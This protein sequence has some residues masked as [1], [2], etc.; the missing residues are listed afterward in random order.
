MRFTTAVSAQAFFSKSCMT[1]RYE[2][3]R[4]EGR[5]L[6]HGFARTPGSLIRMKNSEGIWESVHDKAIRLRMDAIARQVRSGMEA[7]GISIL[8][9][10]CPCIVSA[11]GDTPNRSVELRVRA[12]HRYGAVEIKWS[13]YDLD[14]ACK[15]AEQS[16]PWMTKAALAPGSFVM[17]G[18]KYP[19][20]LQTVGTLGVT[21]SRWRLSLK[22]VQT[23]AAA[24]TA[25]G[26]INI[27]W[28]GGAAKR[29]KKWESGA[30]NRKKAG[31]R[32]QPRRRRGGKP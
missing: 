11:S 23:G 3:W 5:A 28:S 10:D 1:F 17:S 26:D 19:M 12:G 20:R 25:A 4:L 8:G 16:L 22:F 13:R 27:V 30:S 6:E 32:R 2:R 18:R 21:M 24:K 31:A 9:A 15:S 29:K 14:A 7:A